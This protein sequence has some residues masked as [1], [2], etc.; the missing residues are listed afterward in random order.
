M[1]LERYGSAPLPP[2]ITAPLA[3]AERYQT[4]YA[5]V[6]GSAAAPTAGLHF[7]PELFEAIRAKGIDIAKVDL[8]VGLDTFRPVTADR[9]ED[10]DIHS[11]RFSVPESTWEAVVRTKASGG[12]VVAVGTTTVRSLE[13]TA[14]SGVFQ[15]RTKLLIYGDYR[16]DAVDLLMTNF[17]LPR[18]SLLLLVEAFTGTRWRSLYKMALDSQYRFLSLGDALLL[19]RRP[20]R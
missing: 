17:H 6:A 20:H 12:R 5:R 11:E 3:N 10:H 7:T 1:A 13:T 18:S 4:T 16:F 9:P 8:S 19:G 14:A 2:Y 15:G